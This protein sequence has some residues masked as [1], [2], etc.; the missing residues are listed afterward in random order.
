MEKISRI[1]PSNARTKAVDV[2]GSQPVRPG[3]PGWGRPEGRVTRSPLDIEDRVNISNLE[4]PL[5]RTDIYKNKP[6][7]ARAK[8]VE[9]L[10]K[11]FFDTNPVKDLKEGVAPRSEELLGAVE[12]K[13]GFVPTPSSTEA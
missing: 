2:S 11:K 5:D 6:E 3:A 10:A 12:E 7:A 8:V 1:I 13:R 9:D 4:R